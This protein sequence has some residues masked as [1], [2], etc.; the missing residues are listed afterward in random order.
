MLYNIWYQDGGG[1]YIEKFHPDVTMLNCNSFAGTWNYNSQRYTRASEELLH[2][3]HGPLAANY[4]QET[5]VKET[6]R[7]SSTTWI[8]AS[9]P[10]NIQRTEGGAADS[11]K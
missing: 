5:S 3:D 8:T 1:Q 9:V 4:V 6:L 11:E 10:T 2:K 7:P